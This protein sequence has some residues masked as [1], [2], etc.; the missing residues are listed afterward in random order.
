M[1]QGQFSAIDFQ[2]SQGEISGDV[3]LGTSGHFRVN[4]RGLASSDAGSKKKS[5]LVVQSS[6]C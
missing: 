1:P 4:R 6:H 3:L 5:L 2:Q